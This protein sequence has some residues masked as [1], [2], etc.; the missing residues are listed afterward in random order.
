MGYDERASQPIIRQ[1]AG[2]NTR[3]SE[4]GLPGY[5]SPSL[6]NVDLKPR[7]AIRQRN[8]VSALDTPTGETLINAVMRLNQPEESRGWIY[9]IADG[10]IY[11]TREP[12]S[13]SWEEPLFAGST[14]PTMPTQQTYG[15]ENA[16]WNSGS[17]EYPTV[18]YICRSDGAPIVAK[19]TTVSL[20]GDLEALVQYAQGSGSAGTG[21]LGYPSSWGTDHWPTH[22][23]LLS[24]G[25]GARMHA[26]GIAEDPNKVYYSCL[27]IPW[28]YG[29]NDI[30]SV[31]PTLVPDVDGGYYYVNRGD[32]D[33][34]ISVIDMYAYTVVFKE[35]RTYLFTGDPGDA[36]DDFW[37]PV[38][39]I[40]IGCVSDRAWQRVG[41]DIFF[42]S[43]DGPRSLSAVREYG[44]LQQGNLGLKINEDV[45][46]IAPGNYER[47]CS[48]HDVENLRVIWY[49]PENGSSYNN[50]AYVYYYDT[51]EWVVWR[52][53]A[54]QVMDVQLVKSTT[55][56]PDRAIAGTYDA[57]IVQLAA[58]GADVSSD[59]DSHYITNWINFGEVSDASR[60]LSLTVL[61]GD[62]G[63][64][65]DIYYQVDLEET[66]TAVPRLEQAIGSSG[67]AWGSFAWGSAPW[68]QAGRAINRY[69]FD[70]LFN[71]IRLKFEKSG[72]TGFGVMGYRLEA[73][74]KGM[75]A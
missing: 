67:T 44:D 26:W 6:E 28:H 41:N 46:S 19:G 22:M 66:W 72:Q 56:S 60:A 51:G 18:L 75:R 52:G 5:D 8:G 11:R 31:S 45:S 33:R 55:Q 10:T 16:R 3:D 14:A 49:V 43:V 70:A 2:L 50:A 65:V 35:N 40:G 57:G 38:G 59:I 7:G 61:F 13:W 9:V 48:W 36:G 68:G 58:G 30:D 64:D 47:I 29:P 37:T 42:W 32:G 23:R 1:F 17:T 53:S 24:R 63:T 39:E 62:D 69:E 21:T 15:R 20:I 4:I 25:R 27:D 12:A 54:T 74:Q 71:L 73:R 34:V